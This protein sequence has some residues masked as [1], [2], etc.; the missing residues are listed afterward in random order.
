MGKEKAV[1]D[2]GLL[3]KFHTELV[4]QKKNCIGKQNEETN[5]K[6]LDSHHTQRLAAWEKW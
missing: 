1:K 3:T 2:V 4:W 5:D 6:Q